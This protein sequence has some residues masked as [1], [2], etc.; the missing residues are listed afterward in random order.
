M[1]HGAFPWLRGRN[2]SCGAGVPPARNAAE[3]AAPQEVPLRL[4]RGRNET[5]T[6]SRRVHLAP[7]FAL[8]AALT[9]PMAAADDELASRS[10]PVARYVENFLARGK[11]Q[12]ENEL[13][14]REIERLRRLADAPSSSPAI[15]VQ[16]RSL[17]APIRQ[18]LASA[19][20]EATRP[21]IADLKSASEELGIQIRLMKNAWQEA[22]T[23]LE[24]DRALMFEVRGSRTVAGQWVLLLSIDNRQFWLFGLVAI[25]ALVILILHDRRIEFR[26]ALSGGHARSMRLSRFLTIAGFVLLV[27][28][29]AAI[30]VG[31]R[32]Y[33]A[34]LTVGAGEE[35][36]PR[37]TLEA[38][39][40]RL[41]EEVADLDRSHRELESRREEAEAVLAEKY[42]AALEGT[43]TTE[44]LHLFRVQA[45]K[46][47]RVGGR[48][49]IDAGYG[50]R[51]SR[52]GS[53][54]GRIAIPSR[55]DHGASPHAEVDPR[56]P[57]IGTHR[58]GCGRR[59]SFP[60]KRPSAAPEVRQHLPA[61]SGQYRAED[62]CQPPSGD[63]FDRVDPLREPY[64]P[65]AA[66]RVRLLVPPGLPPDDQALLS[67]PGRA[68]GGQDALADDALLAA[69]SRQLSAGGPV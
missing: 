37:Q 43:A 18:F 31:Q 69:Q 29:I 68:Q 4:L 53:G 7:C 54:P 48:R 21:P 38:A 3:T 16:L 13:M 58:H 30:L 41:E 44:Q 8:L 25:G 11:L 35:A 65:S 49:P 5:G 57:G 12:A 59:A 27:A 67:D 62:R 20:G 60:A 6:G 24:K 33:E 22:R 45:L 26:R 17:D 47:G 66:S 64:Q 50:R 2:Q 40:E 52:V 63:G 61:L 28:I 23:V 1:T 56:R 15:L 19:V 9:A 51:P 34:T 36:S 32:V 46:I 55:D 39:S 10:Y 14:A 42:G